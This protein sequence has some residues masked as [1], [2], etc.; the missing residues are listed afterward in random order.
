[1]KG[2]ILYRFIQYIHSHV[3][4]SQEISPG[5]KIPPSSAHFSVSPFLL[6]SHTAWISQKRESAFNQRGKPTVSTVKMMANMT[7]RMIFA[8][9]VVTSSSNTAEKSSA[10]EIIK[11]LVPNRF[12]SLVILMPVIIESF[13]FVL[14]NSDDAKLRQSCANLRQNNNRKK[15]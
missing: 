2:Q 7:F 8:C 13:L 9:L 12:F 6:Q 11:L 4:H 1:M 14:F 3:F 15:T 10:M 5:L